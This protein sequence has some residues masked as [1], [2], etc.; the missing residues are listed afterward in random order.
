M[1]NEQAETLAKKLSTG[2]WT[3]DYPITPEEAKQL[4]LSVS[5][6]MPNQVLELMALYPQP[7]RSQA[8]GVEYLPIPRQK[9]PARQPA[10]AGHT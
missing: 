10:P 7:V 5:T 6:D 1:T 8:G 9:Q 2:T 3:H 4:G